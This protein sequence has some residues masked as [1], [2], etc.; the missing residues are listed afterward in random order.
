MH[1][2]TTDLLGYTHSGENP[3]KV[4]VALQER[5]REKN[6][7]VAYKAISVFHTLMK[8][9]DR[10]FMQLMATKP[11]N[12][13]HMHSYLDRLNMEGMITLSE[14]SV[15]LRVLWCNVPC[16]VLFAI[17]LSKELYSC[18]GGSGWPRLRGQISLYCHM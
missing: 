12:F 15:G 9:G 11:T 7:I 16:V 1:Y 18:S 5:S 3:E 17:A 13:G 6:W 4:Y 10:R 14:S 8:D 2:P